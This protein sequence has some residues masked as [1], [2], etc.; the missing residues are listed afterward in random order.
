MTLSFRQSEIL[1]IARTEGRVAVE[2]LSCRLRVT[3]QTIR[4]DLTE[5]ANA[6]KLDRVHGG[7]VIRPGVANIAYQERRR[8]N[9]G[10]KAA[11][12]RCCARAIPNNSSL[13]LNLG[14]TTEA[15]AR[16]LLCH[17]NMTVVTNNMN[18]ANI[19][20]ANE[21]CE[22]VVAGGLLRRADCGLVGNLA[23]QIIDQ[24]KVDFAIIGTSGLDEEGDLLDFDLQEIHVSR[25][26]IRH[27]RKT[28]LVTDASKF[29]RSAPVRIAS[30]ADVDA[31]FTDQ[32]LPA[33]VAR[34]CVEWDTA[35]HLA[36]Q[37]PPASGG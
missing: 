9:E 12:A 18:V 33:S 21:G 31:I 7:A 27:A 34:K 11:I 28:Y 4:R 17:K 23:T 3:A 5:L 36:E 37:S 19:L 10:A 6:G 20:V 2:D 13:F 32:P 24:F 22:I 25:A 30:L 35:I 14:S 29:A 15:V 16:E 8:L 26:I 1:D